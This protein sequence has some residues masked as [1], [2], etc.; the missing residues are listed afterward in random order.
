MLSKDILSQERYTVFALAYSIK[1]YTSDICSC[2]GNKIINSRICSQKCEYEGTS[3][4]IST[5]L[6]IGL[7]AL[8]QMYCLIQAHTV[9]AVRA[10]SVRRIISL[11]ADL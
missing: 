5:S 3:E 11:G 10:V 4:N 7:V 8:V 6:L 2:L 9:N 1:R